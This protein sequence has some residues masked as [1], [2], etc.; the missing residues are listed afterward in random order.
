MSSEYLKQELYQ[1]VRDE[2][3]IFDWL[4]DGSLDGVWYWDLE[5]PEN[6]WLSPRFKEI[7]GYEDHEVPNTSAWWQENIFQEDL[8]SVL[9]AFEAHV[10][11]G[12]PY[13]QVVRYRHKDGS[14]VWV[15][16]RG[17]AKFNE[18]G[19]P[20]RMLGAHTELAELKAAQLAVE[21]ANDELRVRNEEL[22]QFARAASHDLKSPMRGIRS[23]AEWILEDC[24]KLLPEES[25]EDFQLLIQRVRRMEQLLTSMTDYARL[26][27]T[28]RTPEELD[29]REVLADLRAV[30]HVPGQFEISAPGSES[31]PT[32]KAPRAAIERI[33]GNLI[34]NAVKHHDDVERGRIEIS[35]LEAG[36]FVKFAV[37][38]NG[39]GIPAEFSERI[40]RM[41]ETLA[42]RDEVEGSG[43][44]LA[45]ARKTAEM[46]GG[47]LELACGAAS[48]GARFI[49]RLPLE[50]SGG[51][52]P[53]R[54]VRSEAESGEVSLAS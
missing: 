1:R 2:E 30:L 19:K 3:E 37:Q 49:V 43:M 40:F 15:R 28:D 45:L 9:E 26:G 48:S 16:C 39:P 38:D 6:E 54:P 51:A 29:L 33:F 5:N 52:G 12:K 32:L 36:G 23:L 50:M 21:A 27:K 24:G 47:S 41:F 4:Q 20:V 42:P 17:K 7:F 18:E 11:E 22:D 14:T 31:W 44:G 25:A 35:C 53:G 10:K 46:L 34:S 13:D 8:P